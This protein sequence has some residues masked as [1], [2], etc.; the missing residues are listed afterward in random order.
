M[1]DPRFL[2]F[3]EVALRQVL[4][5]AVGLV[6]AG[7]ERAPRSR[8]LVIDEVLRIGLGRGNPT[9]RDGVHRHGIGRSASVGS[10]GGALAVPRPSRDLVLTL[11]HVMVTPTRALARL[12]RGFVA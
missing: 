2:E 7:L 11:L 1:L 6:V 4:V 5:A 3:G 8:V 9:D 10:A 12:L